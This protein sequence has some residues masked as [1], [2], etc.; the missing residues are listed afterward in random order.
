MNVDLILLGPAHAHHVTGDRVAPPVDHTN[1]LS[2]QCIQTDYDRE[3]GRRVQC[4]A[5]VVL[6]RHGWLCQEHYTR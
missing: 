2:G 1:L 5:Q 3:S 6:K 4:V